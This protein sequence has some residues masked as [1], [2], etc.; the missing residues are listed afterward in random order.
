L[1]SFLLTATVAAIALSAWASP[2]A[3]QAEIMFDQ[4]AALN[5]KGNS[6][7]AMAM[8]RKM[9]AQYDQPAGDDIGF[10]LVRA[11]AWTALG[12]ALRQSGQ[13]DDSLAAFKRVLSHYPQCRSACAD[14]GVGVGKIYQKKGE[15]PA[16]IE[17]YLSVVT[18]YP[19]RFTRTQLAR[20]RI[21]ELMANITLSDDLKAR[22]SQAFAS[23]DKVRDEDRKIKASIA[24]AAG[25]KSELLALASNPA[26]QSSYG[27]LM[28]L[29]DAQLAIDDKIN[30]RATYTQ[31]LEAATGELDPE[32]YGLARIKTFYKLGDYNKVV[33]EAREAVSAFSQGASAVEFHYYLALGMRRSHTTASKG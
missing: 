11:Q 8:W 28:M 17:Q 6:V 33:S 26:V 19:E 27:R 4:G 14:A 30:A 29:A 2:A 15:N 32:G 20:G 3:E 21:D 16:A 23:D 1:I 13:L 18:Q 5:D 12:E 31:Y 22:I 7:D 24:A 25:S 10:D 9:L